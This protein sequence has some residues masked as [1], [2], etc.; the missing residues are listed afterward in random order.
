MLD[1]ANYR[2][3]S[4]LASVVSCKIEQRGK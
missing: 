2:P 3:L 1:L 4:V